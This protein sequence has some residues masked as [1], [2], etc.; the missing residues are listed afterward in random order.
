LPAR[1]G[2]RSSIAACA[3]E[4]GPQVVDLLER[5]DLV[6]LER[7]R[8]RG[9]LLAVLGLRDDDRLAQPLEDLEVRAL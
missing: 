7:Q 6:F 3:T 2:L 9:E 1:S 8:P 4:R 5:G